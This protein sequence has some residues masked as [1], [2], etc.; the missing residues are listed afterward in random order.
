MKTSLL[1][2]MAAIANTIRTNGDT[3][4]V[5]VETGTE[6]VLLLEQIARQIV[7]EG[8][9][10]D[11]TAWEDVA[12]WCASLRQVYRNNGTDPDGVAT[13]ELNRTVLEALGLR[14]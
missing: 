14:A 5:S 7:A 8:E 12:I 4:A 6:N 2:A 10:D 13:E 9:L 3:D 1:I 11:V